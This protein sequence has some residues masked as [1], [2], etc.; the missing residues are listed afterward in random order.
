MHPHLNS[1]LFDETTILSRLDAMAVQMAQD[2]E[3]M[4]L[5]VV[6]ILHGALF[7]AAD[8][9]RRLDVPLR[10]NSLEVS[11]YQG[12]TSCGEITFKQTALPDVR[13]RHVLLI[14]DILDTGHTL[15][16][17]SQRLLTEC[18]PA[19][20]RLCVLLEKRRP[21]EVP[22]K[23]DYVGFE[24]DDEFVVGYGLDYDGKYR[25]LPLIG[26]LKPEVIR[27]GE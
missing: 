11:S 2:Y 18:E 19:S 7:F 5:S 25:N 14:D 27:G 22:V 21:R 12:A 8:L 24:I 10:I 15:T 3:G 13:G 26:T 23:A 17:I 6:P 16:A 9:V 1:I 4:E 20:L